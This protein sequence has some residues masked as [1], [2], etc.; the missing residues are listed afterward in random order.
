MSQSH[1]SHGAP[2]QIVD[3]LLV[4]DTDA[5][6]ARHPDASRSPDAP[7]P[8]DVECCFLLAAGPERLSAFNDGHLR[9]SA[10]AGSSLRIRPVTLALRA[11]FAVLLTAVEW[12]DQQVLSALQFSLNDQIDISVPQMA[13]PA[14]TDR[15][16][17]VDHFWQAQVVAPGSVE[18]QVDA[19]VANRDAEVLGCF[20]WNLV[21]DISG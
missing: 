11:G 8:A 20:R 19:M 6:L 1:A 10:P 13:D 15:F 7:T 18:A 17:S 14:K 21:F 5:L 4:F 2:A 16:A 9:V 3:V 12:S